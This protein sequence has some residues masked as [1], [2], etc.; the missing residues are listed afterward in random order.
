MRRNPIYYISPSNISITP[1]ANGSPNDLAVYIQANT[2][3][4][5]YHPKITGLDYVDSK[6]Q[7][8]TLAGKNRRLNTGN[9]T[10]AFSIFVRLQR[11]RK[12]AYLVFA[13]QTTYNGTQY[14]KHP[15][16]TEDGIVEGRTDDGQPV[17]DQTY[18]WIKI[19]EVSAISQG[20]NRRTT[21]FD[22]GI[23][24]TEKYNNNWQLIEAEQPLRVEIADSKGSGTPHLNTGDIIKL[25]PSL[26]K[27]WDTDS[28]SLIDHWT[29]ER[30]TDDDTNDA[31]WNQAHNPVVFDQNGEITLTNDYGVAG[32]FNAA[33]SATFTFRAW[34]SNQE[35]PA[36]PLAS[37]SITI[38]TE[39]VIYSDYGQIDTSPA[40][41]GSELVPVGQS[42]DS[43]D[44]YDYDDDITIAGTTAKPAAFFNPENPQQSRFKPA[45]VLD[46]KT[47]AF[48]AAGGKFNIDENGDVDITADRID[49]RPSTGDGI[50]PLRL[51]S[52]DNTRQIEFTSFTNT[53]ILPEYTEWFG[54]AAPVTVNGN[55]G[56]ALTLGARINFSDGKKAEGRLVLSD[57]T[58]SDGVPIAKHRTLLLPRELNF[59]YGSTGT[60][61]NDG[62][63]RL[64]IYVDQNGWPRLS[65]GGWNGTGGMP[66]A[67]DVANAPTGTLYVDANGFLKVKQ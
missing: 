54:F 26:V 6:Y 31:A 25:K 11:S 43:P 64:K 52:A 45:L 34:G 19:G 37:G 46:Q 47:G 63:S 24:G 17:D 20:T 8:W 57:V 40:G 53:D 16:I 66:T 42:S 32:D 39:T 48:S 2:K 5:V 21:I 14:E 13:K 10:G 4:K 15:Y 27:G 7:E 23:L 55:T 28:S 36:D 62:F 35:E 59:L 51:H 9:Y 58:V 38:Y 12:D 22:T 67:T 61:V 56:D 49:L 30:D 44:T 41:D 60:N 18:W 50:A 1:N 65:S 3:I 29:I 33:Q